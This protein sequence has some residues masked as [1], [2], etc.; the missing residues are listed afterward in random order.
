ML[1]E[2]GTPRSACGAL[3]KTR[4]ITDLFMLPIVKVFIKVSCEREY[5]GLVDPYGPYLRQG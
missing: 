5:S 2:K 3:H 4:I 1:R